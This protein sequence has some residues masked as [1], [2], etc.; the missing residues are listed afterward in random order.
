LSRGACGPCELGLETRAP[1]S[2][3]ASRQRRRV[4]APPS[5]KR[6]SCRRLPRARQATRVGA[7]TRRAS[8]VLRHRAEETTFRAAVTTPCRTIDRAPSY[9]A[10]APLEKSSSAS[11]PRRTGGARSTRPSRYFQCTCVPDRPSCGEECDQVLGDGPHQCWERQRERD[12]LW[13]RPTL[14]TIR[15]SIRSPVT[16][17]PR[18]SSRSSLARR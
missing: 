16:K 8:V 12:A 6:R 11:A 10:T 1:G 3:R 18:S 4:A 9:R 14:R 15:R 13:L 2:S 7:H 5:E 17:G